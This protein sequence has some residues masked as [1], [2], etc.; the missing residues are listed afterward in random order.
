MKP[1]PFFAHDIETHNN[2]IVLVVVFPG[3]YLLPGHQ[4][5]LPPQ[6]TGGLVVVEIG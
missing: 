1:Y 2:L 3:E 6:L 4:S 5:H